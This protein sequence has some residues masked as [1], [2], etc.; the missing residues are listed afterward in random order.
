MFSFLKKVLGLENDVDFAALV[1]E[2]AQIVDVR[3][4]EEFQGGHIKNAVNI[5]LQVL[6]HKLS[7]I[8]QDKA[9][10]VCCASGVRSSSA[11]GI[12]LS[13]GFSIVHNGGGWRGLQ[14]KLTRTFH[15]ISER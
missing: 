15:P 3:T 7:A 8:R 2:G 12:L 9:V 4:P 14:G 10:I 13:N 11:K 6:S 5:P 1:A